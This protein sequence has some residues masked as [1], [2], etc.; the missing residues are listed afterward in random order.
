MWLDI[1]KFIHSF[2]ESSTESK[3]DINK[4]LS[5]FFEQIHKILQDVA[6]SLQSD[7]YPHG[8]C[9]TMSVLSEQLITTLEGLL[10][11][12]ELNRLSSMLREASILE[13]EFANRKD[14]ETISNLLNAAGEFKALAIIFA[15]KVAIQI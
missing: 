14:P 8:S 10:S 15:M 2:I 1:I 4:K 12:Q 3:K 6:T 7:V 5:E 9:A 11:E 13:K